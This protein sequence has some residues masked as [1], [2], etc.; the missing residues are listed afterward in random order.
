MIVFLDSYLGHLGNTRFIVVAADIK[1]SQ[2]FLFFFCK[3]IDLYTKY[4]KVF[5]IV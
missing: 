1:I 4:T 2:F 3:H 5:Q